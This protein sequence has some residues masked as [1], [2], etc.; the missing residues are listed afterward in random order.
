MQQARMLQRYLPISAQWMFVSTIAG[1]V[2]G[3]MLR[4]TVWAWGWGRTEITLTEIAAAS[5]LGVIRVDSLEWM[6]LHH[7]CSNAYQWL[8]ITIAS[9]GV[10]RAIAHSDVLRAT[11]FSTLELDMGVGG[12]RSWTIPGLGLIASLKLPTV[13]N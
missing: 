7:H 5:L 1:T 12:H 4:G 3:G 2:T 9:W 10:T 8:L 6:V 13:K 11:D